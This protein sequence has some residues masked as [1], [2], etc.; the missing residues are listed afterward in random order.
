[1]S[2]KN[3]LCP[4]RGLICQ[5]QMLLWQSWMPVPLLQIC[6]GWSTTSSP[7]WCIQ[8]PRMPKCHCEFIH[9]GSAP[10]PLKPWALTSE[11]QQLI[12]MTLLYSELR[13]PKG[14]GLPVGWVTSGETSWVPEATTIGV[15]S[16]GNWQ[17]SC[18]VAV[19]GAWALYTWLA[20]AVAF[21]S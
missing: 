1:M 18:L 17:D 20:N 8:A 6:L 14:P 5:I 9:S 21:A 13:V 3:P 11:N 2:P 15:G 4:D 10:R 16:E 19:L 12:L 7:L